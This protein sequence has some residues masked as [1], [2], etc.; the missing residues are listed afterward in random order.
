MSVVAYG[1]NTDGS[2]RP[3][4]LEMGPGNVLSSENDKY[5]MNDV[6]KYTPL[7]FYFT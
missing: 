2:C 3:Y 6:K 7:A 5:F 1:T 4:M